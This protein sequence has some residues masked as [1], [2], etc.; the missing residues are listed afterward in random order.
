MT[1]SRLVGSNERASPTMIRAHSSSGKPPTPVP[2]AGSASERDPSSSASSRQRRVVRATKSA[3]VRR[4]WPMTAPWMTGRAF[5]RPAPVATASP[6]SIGPSAT[7]S[8]SISSPPARLIAP[9]TPAPIHSWLF[10]AFA[11]ASASRAL[12]SPSTTASS[13]GPTLARPRRKRG[14]PLGRE[15]R[16]LHAE[17]TGN[18]VGQP[19]VPAPE[20]LHHARN[21][22][23]PDDRHVEDDRHRQPEPELLEPDD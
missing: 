22:E 8:R 1:R 18:V 17:D 14:C 2:N 13:I 7:A 15:R 20:E 19:P 16:G 3:S 12:M 9:A 21:E 23:R 11:I 5:R 10:A 4:S 6:T